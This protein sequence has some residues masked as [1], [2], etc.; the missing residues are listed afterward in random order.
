MEY[1][2]VSGCGRSGTTLINRIL[3]SH[4]MIVIGMERY[5]R[6][7]TKSFDQFV[8]ELFEYERFFDFR[9]TDSGHFAKGISS[10][11]REY[12]QSIMNK[13]QDRLYIGDKI[14]TLFENFPEVSKRF[15][16]VKFVHI[17]RHIYDVAKSWEMRKRQGTLPATYDYKKSVEF[18]N[19]ALIKALEYRSKRPSEVLLIDYERIFGEGNIDRLLGLVDHRLSI[20]PIKGF[21]DKMAHQAKALE[22]KRKDSS[23]TDQQ[24]AYI[25]KTARF[26]LW[27]V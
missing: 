8:P 18:W 9:E 2:F 5:M 1:I 19:S 21:I 14:P 20:E 25:D 22:E 11:T 3:A 7:Y 23:L 10:A 15:T 17:T 6:L 4:P 13:W 26:D 16:R 12:Y 27:N 24:I